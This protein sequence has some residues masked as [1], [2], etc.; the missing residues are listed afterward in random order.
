MTRHPLANS[1]LSD[2]SICGLPCLRR[3]PRAEGVRG[4]LRVAH[5]GYV[6]Q[7]G[8]IVLQDFAHE[9]LKSDLVRKSY[10]GEK[11]DRR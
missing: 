10:L 11:S 3:Y 1:P 6:I 7:T 9:L 2:N 4:G 8:Q 5:G